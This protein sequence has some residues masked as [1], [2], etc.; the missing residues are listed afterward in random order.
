MVQSSDC[1]HIESVFAVLLRESDSFQKQK[2]NRTTPISC[3][4]AIGVPTS[5]LMAYYRCGALYRLFLLGFCQNLLRDRRNH[6]HTFF[7]HI[8]HRIGDA[9]V[10][11]VYSKMLMPIWLKRQIILNI[12]QRQGRAMTATEIAQATRR[13][14]N[15]SYILS[16][17]E[18]VG[19]ITKLNPKF[20]LF[21]IIEGN[22][23]KYKIYV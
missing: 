19:C 6:L 2:D 10:Q 3:I 15:V 14:G 9:T 4:Y 21:D 8:T 22:P 23:N 11:I 7:L 17:R 1:R 16:S 20:C 5:I 12:L 13:M 18:V